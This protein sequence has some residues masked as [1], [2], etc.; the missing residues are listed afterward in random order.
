MERTLV[1]VKPDGVQR[2]LV[3]QIIARFEARG[4]RIAGM[5]LMQISRE[6]AEKHYAEHKGK[7][8]YEGTVAYMTSAPVVVLCLEGQGGPGADRPRQSAHDALL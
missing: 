8:F 3:G 1:I 5:K 7:P 6:T 4:L 2:A